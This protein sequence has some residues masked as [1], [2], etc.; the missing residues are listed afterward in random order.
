[1]KK[2]TIILNIEETNQILS[3]LGQMPYVQVFQLV[4]KIQ[5]QAQSQLKVAALKEEPE[6]TRN[7]TSFPTPQTIES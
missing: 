6:P 4:Q 3:A 2:M 5:S 1:M 7:G